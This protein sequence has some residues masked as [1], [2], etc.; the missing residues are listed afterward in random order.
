[1]YLF[2]GLVLFWRM[3]YIERK[4]QADK[5]EYNMINNKIIL[6]HEK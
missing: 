6:L 2:V 4:I 3:K 1:M 5:D